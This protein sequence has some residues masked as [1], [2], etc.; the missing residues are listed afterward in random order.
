MPR[1]AARPVALVTGASRGIGKATAVALAGSG[2]DVALT[3]RTVHPG[4]GYDDSDVGGHRMLPGSLEETATQIEALGARAQPVVADLLDYQSLQAAAAAVLRSWGR[5][6]VLVN[7]AIY[8]G[9]GGMVPFLELTVE[10]LETRLRANVV[11]Q[12]VMTQS[13]LP[14]MLAAGG[15]VI[16]D[17]SSHVALADPPAPVGQ[18]GWGLGYAASK[19]AFHRMAGILAVEFA[20]R[21]VRA[22]NVD[23]GFV[24]TERQQA[25]AAAN[26]LAGRYRGAP[27]SVPAAAVA[28][29]ATAPEAAALNGQTVRAQKLALDRGLHPDWR[30]P[31]SREGADGRG[32]APPPRTGAA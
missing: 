8:T 16:V 19:G 13:V 26:G 12:M 23:P 31:V 20:D 30:E 10:Q 24:D 14:A 32:P 21:G 3:A 15:G 1:S 22:Y 7:N 17:I 6:D 18:G 9:P 2:Y 25:N 27:P 29:L 4:T 11:A 5:I 28:W